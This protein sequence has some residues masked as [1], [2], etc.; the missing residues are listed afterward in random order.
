MAID[1]PQIVFKAFIKR[2]TDDFPRPPWFF[3]HGHEGSRL[4]PLDTWIKAECKLVRDGSGSKYY[5]SA[6]H[7]F[8]AESKLVEWAT[9]IKKSV[10]NTII[11]PIY[12]KF[13]KPKPNSRYKL[14]LADY[15][16]L[17]TVLWDQMSL[18]AYD[19]FGCQPIKLTGEIK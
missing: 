12:A 15:I 14:Y 18:P 11:T 10:G 9:S 6:F 4:M 17:P 16:M 1:H 2:K 5:K 3:K 7:V 19:I 13:L 8:T